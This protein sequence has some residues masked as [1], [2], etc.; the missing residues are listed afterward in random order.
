M[1]GRAFVAV[2][3]FPKDG[4]IAIARKLR[5]LNA[6]REPE[7]LCG[8][9]DVSN[10]ISCDYTLV[11]MQE[12]SVSKARVLKAQSKYDRYSRPDAR[13]LLLSLR[14]LAMLTSLHL[15]RSR[16]GHRGRHVIRVAL[17]ACAAEQPRCSATSSEQAICTLDNFLACPRRS[18]CR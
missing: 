3:A 11:P 1:Y 5:I 15:D 16:T 14:H 8:M 6:L 17:I 2:D 12:D 13:D 9:M 7:V 18:A 10:C 4:I